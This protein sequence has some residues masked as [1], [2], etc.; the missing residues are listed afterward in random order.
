MEG[1]NEAKRR[2]NKALDKNRWAEGNFSGKKEEAGENYQGKKGKKE[3]ER[4]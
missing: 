3:I 1:E 4:V 2:K